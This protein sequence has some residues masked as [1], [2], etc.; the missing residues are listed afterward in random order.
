MARGRAAKVRSAMLVLEHIELVQEHTELVRERIV[1]ELEAEH[2]LQKQAEGKILVAEGVRLK[3]V[4]G[5]RKSRGPTL[6]THKLLSLLPVRLC[7]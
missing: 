5:E 1:R 3:Q 6:R 2:V 4:V 7:E